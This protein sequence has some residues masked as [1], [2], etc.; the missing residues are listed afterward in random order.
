MASA[1]ARRPEATYPPAFLDVEVAGQP[2]RMA[3][4]DVG[5][6]GPGQKPVILLL[7]GKNFSG[8]YWEPTIRELVA[9]G[10]RVIA[11][12]QIG[13][14]MSSKPAI[15]YSFH[16][17]ATLTARLLDHLGIS[18]VSVIGHSMGGMLA[19][20]FALMTPERVARLILED[21]IGLEDYRTLVRYTSVDEQ[22]R[23]EVAATRASIQAYQKNYYVTWRPEYELYVDDQAQWLG[24]GEWP[25][26]AVAGALTYDMIYTQ[27]VLYELG[28]LRAPTLVMVG[29]NDRT[30]VGKAKLPD[31]LRAVAGDYP[32]LGKRAHEAIA[33]SRLIAI[34]ACGHI[35]HVEAHEAFMTAVL[36]WLR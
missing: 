26:V 13:F 5:R 6:E 18:K 25:R 19:V 35:P 23:E 30:V 4:R 36:Q 16:L 32:E 33:D 21:P 7:H 15:Q 34:P 31:E 12:D 27:P 24:T 10:F 20:R 28:H 29:V 14:G 11:P 17:L 1:S 2:L 9:R 22:F 8:L 3:Y